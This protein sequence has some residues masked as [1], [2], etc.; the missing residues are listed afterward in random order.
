MITIVYSTHKDNVYNDNF[1]KHLLNSVGLKDVQIL[2]YQ[3]NNQYSLAEVY[4]RGISESIY[5]I[6]VCCHN[7]IKLETGWGKKLV[8]DFN[9]NPDYG[10]IGKAGS[11]YFP[12][13]GVYWEN[14]TQ[15]MVG[16]VY[17]HPKGQNKW[18]NKYS[19]KLP[20]LIPVV[21]I[22][23]LF[24]SFDKNKI[25]HK[26]DENLG[27]FHFYD[28]GFTV[29]N[30]LEGVKLGITSSF[31]ITHESVGQPNDE[32][33]VSKNSFV[34]K[35]GKNLPLKLNPKDVFFDTQKSKPIKNIGKVAVI[36]PVKEN[37][38]LLPEIIE[39][40]LK[41]CEKSMYDIFVVNYGNENI[42]VS[43]DYT[44][45]TSEMTYINDVYNDVIKNL[46]DNYEYIFFGRENIIVLNNV[47]YG[48]VKEFKN[49]PNIG[50]IGCRVH[51]EDNLIKYN[52]VV[53]SKEQ[54]PQLKNKD[55]FYNYSIINEEVDG[56]LSSMMMI[57]K[58][59]FLKCGGFNQN[60]ISGL[61]DIELTVGLKN[62]K[63]KNYLNGSLVCKEINKKPKVKILTGF[64][65]KGGST[66]AFVNLVNFLNEKGI[67]TVLYG[68]HKWHLD[69]CK[70][71]LLIN[72]RFEDDD[73]LV[74]HFLNLPQRPKVKKVILSCHEKDL[75]KV[76]K[77]QQYWDE[78]VFLNPEHQEY[79]KDY[80]G[81]WTIIPNLTQRLILKNK[82]ELDK[83][84]GI[85]GSFDFN[86]QTHVSIQRALEDNCEK[87]YLFGEP[88]GDYYEN[89]VKPLLS[90]KVELKGFYSNKQEMY[91]MIGRVYLSSLSEVASLVKD[92]C[93]L[94]G[95]KFYGTPSTSHNNI[96]LSHDE[97]LNKW[98]NLLEI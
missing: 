23:G 66:F 12:E 56:N 71:D 37:Y 91:D 7:D 81:K 36:I 94:T 11:C 47:I 45:L 50:T 40:Y 30:Y 15:T 78:V 64:S 25:K 75:F 92:E 62:K 44:I 60:N 41:N 8:K 9:D 97:I 80:T 74:T 48:M 14:M 73:V 35:Y 33:W 39:S 53:I 17:H 28:H 96:K 98:I 43:N 42:Q 68:P 20:F 31:E 90:E 65:H 69:K 59:L 26:F 70:S 24:L 93:E 63:F 2:E 77:I 76:G 34:T 89:Y 87:I 19:P 3:N 72:C 85:I 79:H 49:S 6:V 67:D 22:D 95:T 51:N 29:P 55:N 27:R 84:A 32:F 10:I 57:R 82:P 54:Q 88:N 13:S 46:S 83:I 5:D 1:K 61:E 16:Q 21:T 52:G 86:K 38:S 4:N 18:L 58:D